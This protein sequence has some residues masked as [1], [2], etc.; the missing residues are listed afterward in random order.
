MKTLRVGIASYEQMKARTLAIAE[1]NISRRPTSRRF[2]SNPLRASRGF[3]PIAIAPCL[4]SSPNPPPSHL[5]VGG[6]NRAKK[7]ESLPD[8][9]DHGEIRLRSTQPRSAGLDHPEVPYKMISLTLPL[10]KPGREGTEAA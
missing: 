8:T 1:A 6:T 9:E 7:V 10:S 4:G 5:R 2:G 3:C